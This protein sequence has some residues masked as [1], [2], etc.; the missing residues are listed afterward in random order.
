MS[1][2]SK[3]ST[4]KHRKAAADA[5][6]GKLFSR[7]AKEI[8]IAAKQGGGDPDKNIRLR[9]AIQSA[10]S[11]NM[12]NDNI[13]RAIKRGTGELDGVTYEELTYEIYA[14]GGVAILL[15]ILTDN[16]NRTASEIRAV[17]SRKGGSIANSGSV[18]WLFEKKGLVRIAKDKTDEDTLYSTVIDAGAEDIRTE[19]DAFEVYC[20]PE[21][22]EA[23]KNAVTVG[24]IEPDL[25]EVAF[26]P[27]NTV[28]VEGR[29]AE[30]VLDLVESLEDHDD[31]Q[32]LHSNFDIPDEM[33]EAI[34]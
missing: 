9:T 29:E 30:K 7:M 4:I 22:F 28:K 14:P 16:K 5:K 11:V 23:V 3:W 8:I 1:G 33:L 18:A 27:K 31:V 24:G 6:R 21:N 20:E 17:L 34:E 2:H 25:A 32:H 15:D 19:E 26:I 13:E 10:R 12:P